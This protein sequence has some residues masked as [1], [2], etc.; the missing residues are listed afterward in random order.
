[1][2]CYFHSDLDG[3]CAGALV[4]KQFPSCRMRE[5]DYKD[6]PDFEKEVKI[7]EQVFIVDFSFAP[8]KMLQLF[9]RTPI[10]RIYWIDHHET[11]ESYQ[12]FEQAPNGITRPVNNLLGLRDFS[13]ECKRSG[14]ELT[15]GFFNQNEKYEINWNNLPEAVRLIGDYDCWRFDTKEQTNL[16]QQGMKLI[17]N[18]PTDPI[19]RLLLDNKSVDLVIND[20][21]VATKYRDNFC[22]NYRNSY[23]WEVEFEGYKC[24][25][26]NL[27]TVGSQGFG[28]E[29]D[30]HDICLS[31]VWQKDKWTV[32]LYSK[33]THVGEIAQKYGGGGHKGAAGFVCT[34]LPF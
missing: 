5:I 31:F 21:L 30:N 11:A 6:D 19:W 27:Y 1:M 25:A 7:S 24:Y 12:Y 17:P 9:N 22:T 20:G 29:F 32:S 4:L 34:E 18:T 16:F 26:M 2:I 14:A 33:N 15:W 10:N 3:R 23:G 28:E 8:R 13:Q